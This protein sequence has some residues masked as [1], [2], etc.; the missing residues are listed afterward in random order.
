[1]RH[2]EV[3]RERSMCAPLG[4]HNG[5][6][7]IQHAHCMAAKRLTCFPQS[8][9]SCTGLSNFSRRIATEAPQ[10]E[11]KNHGIEHKL[12][13]T[14]ISKVSLPYSSLLFFLE[15]RKKKKTHPVQSRMCSMR[16][17]VDR[18]TSAC[19]GF[20]CR[21]G[22]VL[23]CDMSTSRRDAWKVDSRPS[24]QPACESPAIM[25][26]SKAA[27]PPLPGSS[28]PSSSLSEYE[29]LPYLS[30]RCHWGGGG[31]GVKGGERRVFCV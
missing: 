29:S 15:K 4:R 23:A 11:K 31:A 18:Q 24:L 25:S 26:V 8:A 12:S 22:Q 9:T 19:C 2:A 20:A 6:S 5:K 13:K 28:G 30:R 17:L 10:K 7:S 16:N 21:P 3:A 14:W 1:M 27:M